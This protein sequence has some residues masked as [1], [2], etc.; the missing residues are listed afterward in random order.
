M[1]FLDK[2]YG[3][4]VHWLPNLFKVPHGRYGKSFVAELVCLF[5]SYAEESSKECIAL[6][7]AF[8][9]PLLMLQKP[10]RRSKTSEHVPALEHRLALWRDG[11]FDELLKE[12]ETIQK[13]FAAGSQRVSNDLAGSFA[14]LMFQGKMKAALRLLNRTGSKSGQPLSLDEIVSTDGSNISVK[15]KL[16][17]KHPHP[18][19]FNPSH[20]I[21]QATPPPDHGP[22]FIEFH[23][24][25]GGLIRF[26]ILRMDGAAG[27]SGMDVSHWKKICT[28]FSRESDNVCDSIAMVARKL[29]S[30]YADPMGVSALVASRLIALDKDPEVRPI[31]IGE[32]IRR[33]IGKAIL[34]VTK[35]N[36]IAITGCSQL[37]A[38]LVLHVRQLL[39]LL[40]MYMSL[41]VLRECYLLMHQMRLI[42]CIGILP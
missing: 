2:C 6:K 34:S 31:G 41:L 13:K 16:I 38:G 33:M 18:A 21:L 35:S 9:F 3:V 10:H 27:P 22:H 30:S 7:A 23:Q 4:A 15:D 12:G 14:N 28:S 25:N 26:M 1:R 32:V 11:S 5:C 36:V 24:I 42:H 8:L 40:E 20:S 29:C 17:E 19:P 39:K 37:C